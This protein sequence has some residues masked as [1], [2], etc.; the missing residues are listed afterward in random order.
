MK[1]IIYLIL[2][3]SISG[4]ASAS[5][6]RFNERGNASQATTQDELIRESLQNMIYVIRQD[7]ILKG[8]SG[9]EYGSGS[10]A[11]YGKLFSVGVYCDQKLWIDNRIKTPWTYDKNY[12]ESKSD[13]LKPALSKL[14]MRGLNEIEFTQKNFTLMP[15]TLYTKDSTADIAKNI[16]KNISYYIIKDLQSAGL[17]SANFSYK[18]TSDS[19]GWIAL[20]YQNPKAE[21]SLD[22]KGTLNLDLYKTKV[23]FDSITKEAKVTDLPAKDGIL[24]GVYLKASTNSGSIIFLVEGILFSKN[25]NWYI[26]AIPNPPVVKQIIKPGDISKDRLGPGL[27]K[28]GTQKD[29]NPDKK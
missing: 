14:Y 19:T 2:I 22:E 15:D 7:Y 3:L 4:I 13:T 9:I 24:G 16:I 29:Q 12:K 20:V 18:E 23:K 1:K 26:S 11:E 17:F 28:Q 6:Q 27:Q 5:G 10:K 21:I 8:K 25:Q